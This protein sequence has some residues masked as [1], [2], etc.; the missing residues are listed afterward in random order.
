MDFQGIVNEWNAPVGFIAAV[1]AIIGV[2]WA[3]FKLIRAQYR[4]FKEPND[5]NGFLHN[6]G[7]RKKYKIAIVDDEIK[8]FPI[9]YLKSLGYS[10]STYESISLNEVDRLLSFDIIFLDVKGV[11][12]E[13]LDTG[14]AKLLKLV[15]KAKPSVMVIAVSSG[16]YQL[17]LNSFFEDS[18]DVLN[19]PI[20]EIDIE[21][22]ISDLIKYNIDVDSMAEELINM[23]VCSKSKQEKLINKNLIG[24]F[25]GK[26]GH[27]VLCDVVHRNTNHKYSEK[28]STL[29]KRIM[30]RL[31][32][33]S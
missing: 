16:K 14:G 26:I 20:R 5:V 13:D 32:F 18:D 22:S 12:T 24:Y 29:A 28:I 4:K 33:D 3:V 1:F 10:V 21:N 30:G 31:S 15:K 11:V 17:N 23:I 6:L 25:S 19:K 2:L 9:E 7:L 27:D 8:D